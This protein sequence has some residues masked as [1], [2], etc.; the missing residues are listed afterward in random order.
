MT[1]DLPEEHERQE[2][3][4]AMPLWPAPFLGSRPVKA[5]LAVP[6]S[7]SLTNR[8]LLLAAVADAPSRLRAPLRSRDTELMAQAL[9]ELGA[10]VQDVP[11]HGDFGDD[12]LVTP[13]PFER[14]RA[15]DASASESQ[16]T[17]AHGASG[18]RIEC[19][20]AGTVMRFVPALAALVP[21][22]T[23]FHGDAAAERRPMGPVIEAL[24]GLG[25]EVQELGEPG[26]LP[27]AV[28]GRSALPGGRLSI[29]ASVSS[30][31]VSAL[32]LVA[33]R[34]VHGLQLRHESDDGAGVPSMP[35][36][37][38]T[39]QTLREVGVQVEDSEP[40]AWSV[41]PGAVRAM[42]LSIEQDLSNAGPFLAAAVVSGGTVSIPHWPLRTT[43]GGA[44]WQE[45]LPAFGAEVSLEPEADGQ[46]GTFTVSA[47]KPPRGVDL[48]LSQAGELAPTAA[49]ICAVADSP[50][51]LRGIAHLRGHE[52]DRLAAL[53]A[54]IRRIGGR[55]EETADGLRIEPGQLHPAVMHSYEDH[56]MATAAA[57]I[58]LVLD[59][60][61]VEDI[62]TT[63][64]TLPQFPQLWNQMV[65]D[66]V[67]ET[68]AVPVQAHASPAA[69]HSDSHGTR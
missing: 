60:V 11:G 59:G 48:D 52:T 32:L 54:E 53:V 69:E 42:D 1:R 17:A 34:F 27:F 30:Q 41:A 9:R 58:G 6:G 16:E 26:R 49:A 7:K 8:W 5:S 31:F 36:V 29:D 50:S 19:G 66:S 68:G 20:L 51:V 67:L 2:P 64:K 28:I 4:T 63:A 12:W 44:H 25:V 14:L 3:A 39:L 22:R 65:T 21:G 62:A 45:I 33:A 56:R 23:E 18:R 15:E 47:A 35:H 38:M 57:V 61:Q 40:A 13:I 10:Q 24:R 43:Q 37:E 55:A 46:L